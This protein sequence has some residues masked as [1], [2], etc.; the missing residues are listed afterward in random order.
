MLVQIFQTQFKSTSDKNELNHVE[1]NELTGS[2]KTQA[3][4]ERNFE[5]EYET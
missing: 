1:E 3:F 4:T 5:T 2:Y